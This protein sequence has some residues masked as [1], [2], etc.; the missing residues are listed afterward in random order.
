MV[1]ILCATLDQNYGQNC[2]K[3]IRSIRTLITLKVLLESLTLA[4][5]WMTDMHVCV[6]LAAHLCTAVVSC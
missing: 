6:V 4:L 3:N 2:L 1:N 5:C